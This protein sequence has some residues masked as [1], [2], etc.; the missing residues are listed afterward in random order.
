VEQAKQQIRLRVREIVELAKS[1]VPPADFYDAL[2]TRLVAALA[3]VGGAVWIIEE[4]GLDLVCQINF[5]KIGLHLG[6][7]KFAQ[8]AR[9]L[10]RVLF[11]GGDAM[12]IEPHWWIGDTSGDCQPDRLPARPRNAEEPAADSWNRRNFPA[13]LQRSACAERIPAVRTAGVL[14]GQ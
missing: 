1:G 9:L 11:G 12:L 3:A 7:D 8:H 4:D 13:A 2:L 5:H 14:V 6:G 10:Q